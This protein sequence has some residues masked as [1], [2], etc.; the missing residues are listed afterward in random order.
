MHNVRTYSIPFLL[1][2]SGGLTTLADILQDQL[3]AYALCFC[4]L[5]TAAI[6]FASRKTRFERAVLEAVPNELRGSFSPSA[7]ALSCVVISAMILGFSSL[8]AKASEKGGLVASAFP[9]VKA[10]QDSL[11]VVSTTVAALDT[12]TQDIDATTKTI[13]AAADKW[14]GVTELSIYSP[15]VFLM[16]LTVENR[17]VFL[18]DHVKIVAS[19]PDGE[20]I[21]NEEG[22]IMAPNSQEQHSRELKDRPETIEVCISAQR[23]SDG[24]WSKE[25]RVYGKPNTK[26]NEVFFYRIVETVGI[27]A[28][29]STE[30]C[31]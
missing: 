29:S 17:S 7:F 10:L 3:I 18:F 25:R 30:Q 14:L 24:I 2:L 11:G 26:D 19:S 16:H 4:L 1:A 28:V 8:S 9:E 23:K 27:E 6:V 22:F 20:K 5:V 31:T 15:K 21:V 13:A 12:R